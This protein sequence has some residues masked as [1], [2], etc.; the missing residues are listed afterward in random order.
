MTNL[1]RTLIRE[2]LLQEE[3]FGAQSFV[4]HGS[5]TPP[6]AFIPILL[7]D[8][9]IPSESFSAVYGK[10]LY[11][12]Y[13]LKGTWTDTGR[14]GNYIYKL[15]VNLYGF[16]C[17]ESEV[18]LLVYKRPLTPVEQAIELG[19]DEDL[20][21]NLK[22]VVRLKSKSD[23]SSE[24]A[25]AASKFLKG[26]VKG[27]IYNS[28]ETGRSLVAYDAAVATPVAWR[29]FDD[30]VWTKVDRESIKP[31]LTRNSTGEWERE[32]YDV[33][34]VTTMKRFEKL[35]IEKRVVKGS[36]ELVGTSIVSL[37]DGLRVEGRLNLSSTPITSLP[38]GLKVGSDLLLRDSSVSSLPAGLQVGRNLDLVKTPIAVLPAGLSVGGSLN[39]TNTSI[40]QLPED[41]QVGGDLF[42][43][44]TGVTQVPPSVRIGGRTVGL[45]L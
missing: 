5:T 18:A 43:V 12:V 31:A 25:K 41:L 40:T 24:A 20:I 32:R 27:L 28:P 4:Y 23:F 38:A 22:R 42:L 37:P 1:F 10:G 33:D 45:G 17:F 35:P 2:F 3:V 9:F 15:K 13:D 8:E 21:Q 30:A 16:I 7:K 34:P 39:L 19:L 44:G 14:Y 36:L 6:E 26:K 29:T 11:C